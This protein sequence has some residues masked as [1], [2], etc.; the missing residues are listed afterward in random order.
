MTKA[1][2]NP[3][4]NQLMPEPTW[5]AGVGRTTKDGRLLALSPAPVVAGLQT[6]DANAGP[7]NKVVNWL[8]LQSSHLPFVEKALKNVRCYG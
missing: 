7:E 1:S 8:G 4:S 3:S 6:V 2:E 5:D